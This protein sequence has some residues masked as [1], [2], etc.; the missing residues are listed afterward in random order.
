VDVVEIEADLG[1]MPGAGE[2]ERVLD[3]IALVLARL[4]SEA[5]PADAGH[6][7]DLERRSALVEGIALAA[8]VRIE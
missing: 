1:E 7:D 3:L 5:L 4:R 2:V 8:A 6:T